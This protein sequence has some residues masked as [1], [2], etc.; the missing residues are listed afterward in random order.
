MTTAIEV[1]EEIAA[2]AAEI[3]GTTTLSATVEAALLEIVNGR[4]R[5]EVVALLGEEGRFDFAA[6][7][8]AWGGDDWVVERGTAD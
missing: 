7:E 2:R 8:R 4:R 3:L 5:L 1:D 6:A